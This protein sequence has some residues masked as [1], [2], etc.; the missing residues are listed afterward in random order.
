MKKNLWKKFRNEWQIKPITKIKENKKLYNRK[1]KVKI[2]T[3]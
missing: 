2:E 1:N 3:E